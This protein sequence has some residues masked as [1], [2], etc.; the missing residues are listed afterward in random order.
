MQLTGAWFWYV[1]AAYVGETHDDTLWSLPWF[2]PPRPSHSLPLV[3]LAA[4]LRNASTKF[5][6]CDFCSELHVNTPVTIFMS[7]AV[8][9]VSTTFILP[10]SKRSCQSLCRR[11]SH[12]RYRMTSQEDCSEHLQNPAWRNAKAHK[13]SASTVSL[14]SASRFRTN[15]QL[16]NAIELPKRKIKRTRM[17][18][19]RTGLALSKKLKD[20]SRDQG[21]SGGGCKL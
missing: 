4:W 16:R 11:T 7:S 15:A 10:W 9:G 6:H 1:G 8:L 21:T 17:T 2:R 3:R 19:Q 5:K 13:V 18:T 14:P 20:G 12:T